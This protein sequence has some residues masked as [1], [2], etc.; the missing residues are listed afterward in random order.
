MFALNPRVV[1]AIAGKELRSF[2]GNPTGYV[3]LTLFIATSAAAAFLDDGFFS[4]NL[5]DLATLNRMMPALLVFF[6]PAITMNTWS[7]ERRSGTD[8]LLLT[9]P[10]HDGEVVLGKYL[11]ALIVYTVGLLFSLTHIGVLA[12]LGEPDPGL[13]FSTYLGYWLL[14]AL[15]VAVGMAGSMFASNATVAFI[16]GALGCSGLVFSGAAPWSSG[17]VGVL[18]IA[19]VI[20][21]LFYV[22]TGL[23]QGAG[24]SALVGAAGALVLWFAMP[25]QFP[26]VFAGLSAPEHFASFGEGMVRLGDVVYFLGG[27]WATLVLCGL[28]LGRRHW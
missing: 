18:L 2:L 8:E 25:E 20:A 5:A 3:F 16:L 19:G 12:Y 14:G 22:F 26:G 6:V 9:L 23:A 17:L 15:F 13:M 10:V 7:E 21:L 1:G 4:R 28:L 24:L 27:A 11:G